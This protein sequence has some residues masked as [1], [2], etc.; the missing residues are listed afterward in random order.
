[1]AG[2]HRANAQFSSAKRAHWAG[3]DGVGADTTI[4]FARKTQHF[5]AATG[6]DMTNHR[7]GAHVRNLVTV[8]ATAAAILLSAMSNSASAQNGTQGYILGEPGVRQGNMC[9]KSV[10]SD[11][12]YSGYWAPCPGAAAAAPVRR[13]SSY[14]N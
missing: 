4:F 2:D 5:H 1:L 14:Q 11:F 7:K 13:P 10:S 3:S 6:R 8:T 12:Y 9:W